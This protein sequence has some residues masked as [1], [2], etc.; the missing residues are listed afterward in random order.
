[1]LSCRG[2]AGAGVGG[3]LIL[4]LLNDGRTV[5]G[6]SPETASDEQ[7]MQLDQARD[8]HPRRP[9]PHPG[10][11]GR[12]EHPCR[13]HDDHARRHLD[14]NDVTAGPPLG[15]LTSNTPAMERVPAVMNFDVLPDMGRMTAR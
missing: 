8:R 13:H 10:A 9:E 14:M 15:R 11:D 4:L 5:L 1:M 2:G 7:L 12:I 3:L 6:A